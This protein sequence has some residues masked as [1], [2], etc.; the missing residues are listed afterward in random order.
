MHGQ[1]GMGRE[2]SWHSNGRQSAC[3][4][5][6]AP[7]SGEGALRRSCSG[8]DCSCSVS[9]W[10]LSAVRAP[11]WFLPWLSTI[12]SLHCCLLWPLYHGSLPLPTSL[13]VPGSFWAPVLE[14]I[15]SSLPFSDTCPGSRGTVLFSLQWSNSPEFGASPECHCCE[16]VLKV[17]L[18]RV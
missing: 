16:K 6:S 2:R 7:G 14:V 11:S 1:R 18:W 15:E 9:P 10:R 13:P 5:P 4:V 17:W 12:R 8:E 3:R